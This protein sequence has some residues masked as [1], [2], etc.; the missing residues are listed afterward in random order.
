MS[1][2]TQFLTKWEE[3]KT[4]PSTIVDQLAVTPRAQRQEVSLPLTTKTIP[5]WL[6]ISI[7]FVKWSLYQTTSGQMGQRQQS[8]LAFNSFEHICG[9]LFLPI[10]NIK[11]II[12]KSLYCLISF[13]VGFLQ[14]C[15]RC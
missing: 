5:P 2:E 4:S 1:I 7:S 13:I 15:R 9:S 14:K 12:K 11:C 3:I 8:G 10:E 6:A